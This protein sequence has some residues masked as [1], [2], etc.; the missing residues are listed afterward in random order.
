[1][2]GL[3]VAEHQEALLVPLLSQ[4]PTL[5]A[6]QQIQEQLAAQVMLGLLGLLAI[7]EIQAVLPLV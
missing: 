5:T 3:E 4:H 6:G 1:M 2:V 7:Q